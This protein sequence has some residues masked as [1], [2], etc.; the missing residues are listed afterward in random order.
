MPRQLKQHATHRLGNIDSLARHWM[1]RQLKQ[2]ATHRLGNIDGL[3][4]H[5]MPRQLK[6]VSAL[7]FPQVTTN[8]HKSSCM[9]KAVLGIYLLTNGEILETWTYLIKE[10]P[11]FLKRKR[12][13]CNSKSFRFQKLRVHVDTG[14][15]SKATCARRHWSYF[16]SY[17]CT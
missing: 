4:R 3:A 17:V 15:I 5:W 12:K 7:S 2:H 6:Q 8:F 13:S 10:L 9:Q 11:P 1:P 14:L 16:K